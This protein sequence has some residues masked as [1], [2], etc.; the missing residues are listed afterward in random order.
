MRS[1]DKVHE[2]SSR[3][4]GASH[5]AEPRINPQ[6][7]HLA[8]VS[9]TFSLSFGSSLAGV[10]AGLII[11]IALWNSVSHAYMLVWFVGLSVLY[12][13]RQVL[14]WAFHKASPA[15]SE[16]LFW[17]RWYYVGAIAIGLGW[18]L[19]GVLLFPMGSAFHMSILTLFIAGVSYVA[20]VHHMPTTAYFPLILVQLLPLSA[21]YFHQGD[22]AHVT[23]GALILMFA[24]GLILVGRRMHNINTESLTL[25]FANTDLVN[26]LQGQKAELKA[27]IDER[28]RLEEEILRD[29]E[30]YRH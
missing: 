11:V 12:A 29:E 10:I 25:R 15:S 7:I 13:S 5:E 22:Q 28:I 18:G 17:A 2:K 8:Q 30:K 16:M 4:D 19:A 6:E 26:T 23:V 27:Q 24:A 1:T 14:A 21:R 3:P 9:Q 20:T